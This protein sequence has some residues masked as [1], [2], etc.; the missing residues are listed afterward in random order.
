MR[1]IHQGCIGDWLGT[2]GISDGHEL[3]EQRIVFCVVP[4]NDHCQ[5]SAEGSGRETKRT[6]P[7]VRQ[8]IRRRMY[9]SLSGDV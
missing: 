8:R 1:K 4:I 5:A 3:F 7:Q 9:E 2:T 6:N